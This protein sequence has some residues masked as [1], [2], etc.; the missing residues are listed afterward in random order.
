MGPASLTTTRAE[1]H[2]PCSTMPPTR[3]SVSGIVT[4][5]VSQDTCTAVLSIPKEHFLEGC[6]SREWPS[7][8]HKRKI[9]ARVA[10]VV[11]ALTGQTAAEQ[12][13]TS[14]DPSSVLRLAAQRRAR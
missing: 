4:I 3:Q 2:D 11:G 10:D 8:A 12:P 1:K 14:W 13:A 7:W 9:Y 5:I 6:R